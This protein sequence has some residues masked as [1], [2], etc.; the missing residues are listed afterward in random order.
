MARNPLFAIGSIKT[1]I[2][3]VPATPGGSLSH[4]PLSVFHQLSY[5]E[6]QFIETQTP[7]PG[8]LAARDWLNN[9][10]AQES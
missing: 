5:P 2:F 9:T 6:G 4:G 3:I 10:T 1:G 7:V 8:T